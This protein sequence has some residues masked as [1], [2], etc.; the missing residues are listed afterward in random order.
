VPLAGMAPF[1]C[2]NS[3]K[4]SRSLPLSLTLHFMSQACT[5]GLGSKSG[6]QQ[7]FLHR[8]HLP[9][10][11]LS[12]PTVCKARRYTGVVVSAC[13]RHG[14]WRPPSAVSDPPGHPSAAAVSSALGPPLRLP[15]GQ[16]SQEA[17]ENRQQAQKQEGFV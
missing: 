13:L 4:F 3:K 16:P 11:S 9:S 5:G 2:A 8:M 17:S 15:P 6:K 14:Q 10:V 1:L 7:A 12:K